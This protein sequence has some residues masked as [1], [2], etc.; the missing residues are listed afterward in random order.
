MD[1]HGLSS[2]ASQRSASTEKPII[3]LRGGEIS[4]RCMEPADGGHRLPAGRQR[5][6]ACKRLICRLNL[7]V[8]HQRS[9]F[10]RASPTSA[11]W[12]AKR[13]SPV[14][15]V[16]FAVALCASAGAQVAR[17]LPSRRAGGWSAAAVAGAANATP[18][19]AALAGSF[20]APLFTPI[21]CP[22]AITSNSSYPLQFAT[23]TARRQGNHDHLCV[24]RG[25][26]NRFVEATGAV[27]M[28]S[29]SKQV[30]ADW[31]GVT[32]SISIPSVPVATW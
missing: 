32:S 7:Q 5:H 2:A 18:L 14:P 26:D 10:A 31:P 9:G 24:I 3:G 8:Y 30:L 25:E 16:V 1:D 21:Y 12:T 23:A 20:V 28:R 29:P 11:S 13:H 4:I 19:T 27:D 22:S 6:N 17:P 15:A